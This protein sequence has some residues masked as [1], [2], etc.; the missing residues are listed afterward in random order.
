M[1]DDLRQDSSQEA[2]EF[3]EDRI[4][5]FPLRIRAGWIYANSHSLPGPHADLARI[6]PLRT[7]QKIT[8]HV[9][10]YVLRSNQPLGRICPDGIL[11]GMLAVLVRFVNLNRVLGMLLAF[12]VLTRFYWKATTV[13][14]ESVMILSPLGI[15]LSASSLLGVKRHFIA[16]EHIRQ[17]IIHESINGWNIAFY[18]ALIV[19]SSEGDVSVHQIFP[20]LQPQLSYLIPVWKAIREAFGDPNTH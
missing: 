4:H 17:A 8:P 16:R 12:V 14:S 5:R 10:L 2:Q 20:H 19:D 15:Q 6:S 1:V 11:I 7:A 18:L 3:P 9:S 13:T